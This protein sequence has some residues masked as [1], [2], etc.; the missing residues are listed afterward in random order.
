MTEQGRLLGFG[1]NM[2]AVC[3]EKTRESNVPMVIRLLINMGIV[4]CMPA[5]K[6]CLFIV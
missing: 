6:M 5:W 3:M 2:L 1:R 4:S